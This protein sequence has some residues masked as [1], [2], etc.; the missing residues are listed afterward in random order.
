MAACAGDGGRA[1]ASLHHRLAERGVAHLLPRR[2]GLLL[3]AVPTDGDEALGAVR[4]E[5]GP[6]VRHGVS[7]PAAGPSRVPDAAREAMW[8]LQA[9]ESD[10]VTSCRYGEH[11]PLFLPRTLGEAESVV[12]KILGP[13]LEYDAS[14]GSNLVQSLRVFLSCNRSWQRA[15]AQMFVHKQTLVYRMRRVE[16]L[17]QRKLDDTSAVAELWL[18]LRALESAGTR[19]GTRRCRRSTTH[20]T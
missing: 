14:Q 12:G 5:L 9:A 10:G 8:A 20:R 13:L 18:A 4:E 19:V 16:E 6:D 7:D 1:G 11:A 17:T 2:S 3:V 15:S